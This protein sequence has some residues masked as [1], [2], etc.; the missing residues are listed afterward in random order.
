MATAVQQSTAAIDRMTSSIQE[1]AGN[2]EDLEGAIAETFASMTDVS[3]AISQVERVAHDSAKL[4]AQ[5]THDASLGGEALQATL[6]G[7]DRI[8][9]A[10]Q[11]AFEVISSLVRG[12]EQI[13]A[14]IVVIKGVADQTNL[15]ALNASII[16]SQSGEHGKGFGV[17]AVEIKNLAERTRVSTSEIGSLIETIREESDRAMDAMRRGMDNVDQGVRVGRQA[18]EAFQKI[19]ESTSSSGDMVQEIAAAARKHAQRIKDLTQSMQRV[20]Q[21]A[22][23]DSRRI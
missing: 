13:G 20:A 2:I 10:T 21:S 6:N 11:T 7:I 19:L 14:I 16:A 15:L 18:G 23:M 1:S 4:S 17:V 22:K 12:T 9:D 3:K 5:A 8:N